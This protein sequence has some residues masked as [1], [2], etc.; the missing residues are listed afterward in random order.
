MKSKQVIEALKKQR[1]TEKKAFEFFGITHPLVQ[2]HIAFLKSFFK[3]KICLEDTLQDSCIDFLE[4]IKPFKI[5]KGFYIC[6]LGLPFLTTSQQGIMNGGII[7]FYDGFVSQRKYTSFIN[8]GLLVYFYQTILYI[9]EIGQMVFI[10]I[11]EDKEDVIL[12]H[13]DPVKLLEYVFSRMREANNEIVSYR[14][15]KSQKKEFRFSDICIPSLRKRVISLINIEPN[16]DTLL[17]K[18]GQYQ[19]ITLN[20]N[21]DPFFNQLK[22][23]QAQEPIYEILEDLFKSKI[24]VY[25]IRSKTK[26]EEFLF[27]LCHPKVTLLHTIFK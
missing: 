20:P 13:T 9:Q 4:L 3:G 6:K 16:F 19:N 11:P 22:K 23:L 7:D 5:T 8:P 2:T 25:N 17:H 24:S 12:F 15:Y 26:I 18:L 1:K 14:K 10:V 21:E 27:G